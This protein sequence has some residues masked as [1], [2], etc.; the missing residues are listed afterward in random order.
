MVDE[1][2]RQSRFLEWAHVKPQR[3]V[4][5]HYVPGE[6]IIVSRQATENQG[7]RRYQ[8]LPELIG[9]GYLVARPESLGLC[10]YETD[11]VAAARSDW[12][13][14]AKDFS[15]RLNR[16][17]FELNKSDRSRLYG[18]IIREVAKLLANDIGEGEAQLNLPFGDHGSRQKRESRKVGNSTP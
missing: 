11:D 6:G 17:V 1:K 12:E 5:E 8:F 15:E 18:A 3:V 14:A 7:E 4:C 9:A 10:T 16:S 13:T 2:S